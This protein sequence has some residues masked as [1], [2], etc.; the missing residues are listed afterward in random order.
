MLLSLDCIFTLRKGGKAYMCVYR[1]I[2]INTKSF[3]TMRQDMQLIYF[4]SGNGLGWKIF[5]ASGHAW[6]RIRSPQKTR[7]KTQI[8]ANKSK[9]ASFSSQNLLLCIKISNF[10]LL[11]RHRN[12]WK[13]YVN[14]VKFLGR[15]PK[16]RFKLKKTQKKTKI[17]PGTKNTNKRKKTQLA[18]SG[19]PCLTPSPDTN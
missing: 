13:K 8:N 12:G 9:L 6:K 2:D 17:F 19:M 18:F 15:K 3:S 11:K 10:W 4:F 5:L 1:H 14:S 7:R 16:L